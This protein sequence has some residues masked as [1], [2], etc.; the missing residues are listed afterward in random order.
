MHFTQLKIKK[1]ISEEIVE[2]I[3]VDETDFGSGSNQTQETE[4]ETS[5]PEAEVK[6]EV[7]E[8]ESKLNLTT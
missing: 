8:E 7:K 2:V 6:K 4:L 3:G 5:Q 1:F